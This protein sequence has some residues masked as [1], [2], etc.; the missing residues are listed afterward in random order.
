ML[1][2]WENA[3]PEL[4][5]LIAVGPRSAVPDR[6]LT[7][8]IVAAITTLADAVGDLVHDGDT[9]ALEGFTHLIPH[10]A[11]HEII[12]QQPPRPAPGADDTGRRLRPADRRRLRRGAD[13]RLG[14]QP[15][16][17]VAAPAPRRRRARLAAPLELDE[18]SHAGLA[19]RYAAGAPGLPFGVLRGYAGTD[20]VGHTS[21]RHRSTCPFTGEELA[22]VP[23]MRPTSR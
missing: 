8:L 15:R 16:R 14:R 17:R 11:G 12:R 3:S 23:A 20:L 9:V 4:P 10:A 19:S 5:E 13:V 7:P 21:R 1:L 6:L 2:V 22:A 18:N